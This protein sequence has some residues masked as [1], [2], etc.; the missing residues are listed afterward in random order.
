MNDYKESSCTSDAKIK[1][2][3]VVENIIPTYLENPLEVT[4]YT[5]NFSTYMVTATETEAILDCTSY[6]KQ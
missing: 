5:I 3:T 4:S 2:S 1:V 6:Y